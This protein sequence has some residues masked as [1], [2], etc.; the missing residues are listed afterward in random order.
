MKR[1]R[2]LARSGEDAAQRLAGNRKPRRKKPNFVR[3]EGERLFLRTLDESDCTQC[4]VAWLNDPQIVRFLE[5]RHRPQT[6]EM[7]RE[8]VAAINAK[9][10]EH[11]FGIFL[12]FGNRHIGNI[13]IGPI[14]PQ[15][16]VGDVSLWIGDRSCWARGYAT[17]A[18]VTVSRYAFDAL[19]VRK[20]AANMYELNQASY[21]AFIKAG[22]RD[23][24]RRR[25]H[26][27]FEGR[28]SDIL[29]TG[30]TPEDL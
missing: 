2:H 19:G 11:L 13:K 21:R 7:I 25:A 26:Y 3:I 30:L 22:Y 27:E 14:H 1:S 24:G 5:I 29:V 12:R 20:L 8:F 15:H 6:L 10:D 28:R 16:R 18:I 4:Y 23:E 9:D 17:E